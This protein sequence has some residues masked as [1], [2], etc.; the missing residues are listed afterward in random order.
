MFN[1]FKNK[2]KNF[3]KDTFIKYTLIT[4][5][6]KNRVANSYYLGVIY[7]NDFI[8]DFLTKKTF[9]ELENFFNNNNLILGFQIN[10]LADDIILFDNLLEAHIWASQ[11]KYFIFDTKALILLGHNIIK[12]KKDILQ[13]RNIFKPPIYIIE[14]DNTYVH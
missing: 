13:Y 2:I 12:A 3:I 1:D 11:K 6:K 5:I 10:T 8:N 7:F 9:I 14:T 4:K